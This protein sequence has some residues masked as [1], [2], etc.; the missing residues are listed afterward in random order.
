MYEYTPKKENN[1]AAHLVFLL[2]IGGLLLL[3]LTSLFQALPFRWVFQI[4]GVVM[5]G[6]AIYLYTRYFTR[7]FCYAVVQREDGTLDFTVTECQRKSRITVCR[8]SLSSIERIEVVKASERDRKK[9]LK[10]EL[11]ANG[12]KLF[13]YTV[14]I[15]PASVCYLV[16]TEC[17]QPL[18]ICFEPDEQLL[19]VLGAGE[20]S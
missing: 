7:I 2:L 16:A 9:A 19:R 20:E 15:A 5:I 14:N 11:S 3:A 1:K 13:A 18:A 10:K 8:L 4:F 17:G 6:I 12:R